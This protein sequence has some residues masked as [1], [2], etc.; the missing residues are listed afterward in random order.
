MILR[1]VVIIAALVYLGWNWQ[2]LL[3]WTHEFTSWLWE[4]LSSFPRWL[5]IMWAVIALGAAL[6]AP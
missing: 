4:G 5:Y 3:E 6:F 2:T 1:I